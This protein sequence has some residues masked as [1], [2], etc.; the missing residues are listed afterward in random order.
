MSNKK[1]KGKQK[2]RRVDFALAFLSAFRR[3]YNWHDPMTLREIAEWTQLI[4]GH[5]GGCSSENIRLI[6]QAAIKSLRKQI[7]LETDFEQLED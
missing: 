5:R 1:H 2:T 6:E 4:V 3:K 7:N